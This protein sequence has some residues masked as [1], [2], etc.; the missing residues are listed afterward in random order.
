MPRWN[1]FRNSGSLTSAFTCSKN[2]PDT[3]RHGV[4]G[5]KEVHRSRETIS[6]MHAG[7]CCA[8][9]PK[10]AEHERRSIYEVKFIKKTNCLL[11][12]RIIGN[13]AGIKDVNLIAH[14]ASPVLL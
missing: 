1:R 2:S 5:R 12:G 11:E 4:C 9:R 6:R 10:V 13:Y 3:G 8:D 7:G 14:N